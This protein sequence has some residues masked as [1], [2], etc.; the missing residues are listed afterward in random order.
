MALNFGLLN[1]FARRNSMAF[2]DLSIKQQF[3][4]RKAQQG[5]LVPQHVWMDVCMYASFLLKAH[6]H[7]LLLRSALSAVIP[8]SHDSHAGYLGKV[9]YYWAQLNGDAR[10]PVPSSSSR[11]CSSAPTPLSRLLSPLHA[12]PSF[13]IRPHLRN[14][15]LTLPC[16]SVL[17]SLP[18]HS[19]TGCH[20][21]GGPWRT[22]S[23]KL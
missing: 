6:P 12:S 14:P 23:S 7:E 3:N 5:F 9:R 11:F 4:C 22:L 20:D 16:P 21:R 15:P 2:S 8:A 1:T 18:R 10:F 13:V 19:R 17:V